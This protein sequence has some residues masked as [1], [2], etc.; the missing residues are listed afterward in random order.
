MKY[1]NLYL[2]LTLFSISSLIFSQEKKI[3]SLIT[4]TIS[5]TDSTN[6]NTAADLI[7]ELSLQ[8]KYNLCLIYCDK[9]I[10]LSKSITHHKGAGKIYIEKANILNITDKSS[11]AMQGYDQAEHF[12]K[13]SGYDKGIA[14]VNNNKAV[15]EHRLGNLE[16]SIALLLNANVYY[17][18][19]KDSISLADTFNNIGNVHNT[20]NQSLDAKEYY[21]KSIE[22][23]RK[24]KLKNLASTLNNLANVHINIKEVDSAIT[25]LN[26]A[27]EEGKLQNDSRSIAGTYIALGKI[28]LDQKNYK[29]AKEYLEASMFVGGKTEYTSR[30]V[31]TKHALALIA[32]KTGDLDQ[33]E[34]YLTNARSKSKELN[35][36]NHL[37]TNY[38]Y[39]A[40]LDSAKGDFTSAARWKKKHMLLLSKESKDKSIK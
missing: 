38:K 31:T 24:N 28:Y 15:I 3:D 18:K 29:K 7:Y 5:I 21:K 10:E 25:I 39:S 40:Q 19:L 32:L 33:A 36:T 11:E 23:K 35:Y 4:S 16:K 1:I 17:E 2:K 30:L 9:L 26:E 14:V 12:F 37:L 20:L 13:L 6:I 22:I 8:E 27:L 34:K